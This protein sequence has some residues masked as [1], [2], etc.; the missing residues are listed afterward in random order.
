MKEIHLGPILTENRRKVGI[1]QEDLARFLGVSKAAVSKW[2][3]GSAYPDILMLPRLASFFNITIDQLMG[4]RPQLTPEEIR[5]IYMDL[6]KEFTVL[7]FGKALEHCREYIRD[8]AIPFFFKWV[9]F[10]STIFLCLHL[11]MRP[12]TLS[13]K[14]W[15]CWMPIPVWLPEI[16]IP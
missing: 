2:E 13:K 10:L 12:G 11:L 8:P 1:T 3:T 4:Y 7:P 9:P 16:F 14:L 6:A 5:Q 15:K